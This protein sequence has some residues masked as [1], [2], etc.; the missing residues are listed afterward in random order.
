MWVLAYLCTFVHVHVMPLFSF[1][2]T[3]T[4]LFTEPG[5]H[6]LGVGWSASKLQ[7]TNALLLLPVLGL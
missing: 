2:V 1:I 4:G 7:E 5:A 6:L 3:E